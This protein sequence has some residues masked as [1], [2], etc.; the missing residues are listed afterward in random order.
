M[1]ISGRS[2]SSAVPQLI[3]HFNQYLCCF[4]LFQKD[5]PLSSAPKYLDFEN[6]EKSSDR[7]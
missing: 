5:D 3:W 7:R 1:N 4:F 6:K 2:S